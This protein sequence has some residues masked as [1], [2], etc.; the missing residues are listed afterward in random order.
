[1][2]SWFLVNVD[3]A[4]P[5]LHGHSVRASVPIVSGRIHP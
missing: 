4:M 5:A 3:V 2:I 1:M